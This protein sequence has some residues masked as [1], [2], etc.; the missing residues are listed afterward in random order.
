MGTA[1]SGFS[2]PVAAVFLLAENRLLREALLRILSK[3]DDIRVVGAGSCGPDM[4]EQIV[5][6]QANVVVLDSVSS[7]AMI[8]TSGWTCSTM[9]AKSL[10]FWTSPT[11]SMSDW[12][13]MVAITNSR[14]KR[15]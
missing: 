9:S 7:I 1:V 15:G 4:L 5:S 2:G 13:A 11:T 14:I 12:S 8:S 3:K 6:T 10:S